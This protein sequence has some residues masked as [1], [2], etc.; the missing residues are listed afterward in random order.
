MSRS[1][2]LKFMRISIVSGIILL[3]T[4]LLLA[5]SESPKEVFEKIR[6]AYNK[7]DM[8]MYKKYITKGSVEMI[9]QM[10]QGGWGYKMPEDA[11]FI[12]ESEEDGRVIIKCKELDKDG[13]KKGDTMNSATP[14]TV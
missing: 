8:E 1:R 12:S 2:R 13:N 9:E 6:K 3:F 7:Q 4:V 14:Q 5:Q 10:L 11:I